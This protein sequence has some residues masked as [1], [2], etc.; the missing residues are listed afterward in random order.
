MAIHQEKHPIGSII[1]LNYKTDDLVLKLIKRLSPHDNWEIVVVDNNPDKSIVQ[2]LPSAIQ[3]IHTGQNLGY[4]GGNNVGI[5]KAKGE[6][7]LIANSDI[8]ITIDQIN[9]IVKEAE[10][11]NNL[12]AAPALVSKD[13]LLQQSV[14][15]FDSF[16]KH[17]INNIFARPRFITPTNSQSMN[18]DLVTGACILV[19]KKVFDTIGMFDDKTY[20][21]YFEDIDWSLRLKK[22]GIHILYVPSVRVIHY[23]GA[24]SDQD[25]RQKN[26]NYQQGLKNYIRKHRGVIIEKINELCGFFK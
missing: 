3:Y 4:A 25:A 5:E 9:T 6:W 12:V 1:I 19:H 15:Y 13:G 10:K 14:G 21:M 2:R 22:E 7:I 17:I 24:S 18:I 8:E 23:G 20:F 26:V 11:D 16:S